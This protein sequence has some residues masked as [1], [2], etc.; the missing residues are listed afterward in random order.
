MREMNFM[1]V[2]VAVDSLKNSLTSYE[3]GKAI[4][5]GIRNAY[6]D[7]EVEVIVKPLADG[8]E[9]TVA[10]LVEGL[11]GEL[12]YAAVHGPLAGMVQCP[13]G[14]LKE[15]KTA[16]IE[17]AGAAGIGL[18]PEEERNPLHTTTYGVGEV[19]V[20]AMSEGARNFII[21]I[22]GSVT[23]DCGVGMLQALGFIF[24]DEQGQPVGLGGKAVENIVS[25]DVSQAVPAIKDCTFHIA[26]DVNNPLYGTHGAAYIFGPQKGATPD[27]VRRLD[28]ASRVF[29]EVTAKF[30]G[31]DLSQTPG[32]GAAGGLGFAFLAYIKGS[33]QS[34]IQIVLNSIHLAE[35]IQDADYV[36]TGEGCLDAQTAMGKAP[37]GVAKLAKKYGAKVIAL[38]GC[39]TD[40][41][42]ACNKHG[43]DAFFSIVDS[44]MSL[45]EAMNKDVAL[46]N[47]TNTAT[48]VFNLI[49]AAEH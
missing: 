49:R 2:V 6:S 11:H 31:T 5:A 4:E 22:G 43:I 32:A 35:A 14:F 17:M 40:D 23:S 19:I 10:A 15:S 24:K 12:R 28:A 46:K 39:T 47:M 16:I 34:G 36:V 38:A 27:M 9:G 8:G 7:T 29:A 20:Q 18:V 41:A 3:A 42:K 13:Y 33:L 21:G 30:L 1:K 44:A 48:Q 25:V 45:K 37:I 26:C